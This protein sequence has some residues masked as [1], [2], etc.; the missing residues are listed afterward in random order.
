MPGVLRHRARSGT[1][2]VLSELSRY[3]LAP[4][5]HTR[6]RAGVTLGMTD[7][8]PIDWKGVPE[9]P[10]GLFAPEAFLT[11]H[12]YLATTL[13]SSSQVGRLLL[14]VAQ[15]AEDRVGRAVLC[16]PDDRV[17][18][19]PWFA[20]VYYAADAL[21]PSMAAPSNMRFASA[22]LRGAR[23]KAWVPAMPPGEREAYQRLVDIGGHLALIAYLD[24]LAGLA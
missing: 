21:L 17:Y 7:P 6:R 2:R 4:A 9:R 24:A 3:R 23:Y 10:S 22:N 16:G 15:A 8:P 12:R 13:V 1:R 14:N 11:E 20:P 5:L 19:L 18:V